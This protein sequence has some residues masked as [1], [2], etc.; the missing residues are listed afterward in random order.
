MRTELASI[1]G[2]YIYN[3]NFRK[4]FI[5]VIF[6]KVPEEERYRNKEASFNSLVGIFM[7]VLNA[8]MEWFLRAENKSSEYKSI[9]LQKNYT[10]SEVIEEEKKVDTYV[11]NFLR[12]LQP[13]DLDRKIV[14]Q[15]RGGNMEID[16][17]GILLHMIE[18]E[19]QH[20]GELNALLWQ[21][22]ILPPAWGYDDWTPRDVTL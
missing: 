15:D 11:M 18:D 9:D 20:R 10:R 4:K 17:R 6:E 5:P 19:L 16:L 7:H 22:D 2:W 13:E 8:Y 12:E 3:S 21:M 1:R 14:W